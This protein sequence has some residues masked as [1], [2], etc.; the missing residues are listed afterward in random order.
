MGKVTVEKKLNVETGALWALI[1][2]FGDVSWMPGGND[3]AR[4]EGEGVGMVRIIQNPAGGDIHERLEAVDDDA[5][6]IHYT[7]PVG[8]PFPVTGYRSTMAVSDDGGK[9]RL[10]WS[11][12]FQPDGVTEAEAEGAIEQMYGVMM[13]WIEETASAS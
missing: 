7:I 13:G 12:E 1:R 4:I 5:Q 3:I 8:V 2:D 6:S 11:C 10:V 9:G